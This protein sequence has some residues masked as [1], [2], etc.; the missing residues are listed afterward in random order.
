[1]LCD[2]NDCTGCGA[3]QNRCPVGCIEMKEDSEGF[4]GP[5]VNKS[6]CTNC[7]LCEQTCPILNPPAVQRSSTPKAYACWNLDNEIRMESSSGGMYSVFAQSVIN[8]SGVV[9]GAA[10]DQDFNLRHIPV[11]SLDHLAQTR[12]SKYVQ[13][14]IGDIYID[15][16][17]RLK[18]GRLV[19][20]SGTPCQIA[21][22]YGFLGKSD[23]SNLL[24]AE[25]ICYG[26][27]SK[28][29]FSAYKVYLEKKYKSSF[30]SINSRD[31]KRGW[32]KPEVAIC[33]KNKK[34]YRTPFTATDDSYAAAYFSNIGLRESCYACHFKENRRCGDLTLADFWGLGLNEPFDHDMKLGVSLLLINSEKGELFFRRVQYDCFNVERT[35]EEAVTGNPMLYQS[36]ERHGYRGDFYRELENYSF[37]YVLNKYLKNKKT[38]RGLVKKI[39]GQDIIEKLRSVRYG[40]IGK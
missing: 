37:S 26:V 8:K 13:S 11:E 19:L 18:E 30:E 10:F 4:L 1:M 35:L 31:K 20:F 16:K 28:S 14:E 5:V 3:C 23:H 22:L 34:Q 15:V 7:L 32:K 25:L 2:K 38:L 39:L 40:S 6:S 12:K 24:T 17:T 36:V 29:L 27:P 21:G 9:Y 33:F